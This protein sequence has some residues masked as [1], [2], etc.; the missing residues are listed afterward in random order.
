MATNLFARVQTESLRATSTTPREAIDAVFPDQNC[1]FANVIGNLANMDQNTLENL[2]DAILRQPITIEHNNFWTENL[3][4]DPETLSQEFSNLP[5]TTTLFLGIDYSQQLRPVCFR[6]EC[7]FC[8]HEIQPL[9]FQSPNELR[10]HLSTVHQYNLSD[11]QLLSYLTDAGLHNH[12]GGME[13]LEETLE[14]PNNEKIFNWYCRAPNCYACGHTAE[15]YHLHQQTFHNDKFINLHPFWANVFRHFTILD[16][17]PTMKEIFTTRKLARFTISINEN[18]IFTKIIANESKIVKSNDRLNEDTNNARI[19]SFNVTLKIYTPVFIA[20]QDST[21]ANR[22]ASYANM[23]QLDDNMF[24]H[25]EM[26][27]F[28]F[29]M[30]EFDAEWEYEG[31]THQERREATIEAID[32]DDFDIVNIDTAEDLEEF[33]NIIR[34]AL[35]TIDTVDQLN[36]YINEWEKVRFT[37]NSSEILNDTVDPPIIVK[38]IFTNASLPRA[39]Y[40]S[41]Y[42]GDHTAF[43]NIQ[44][45]KNYVNQREDWTYGKSTLELS[46]VYHWNITDRGR[47]RIKKSNDEI[48]SSTTP[49][50]CSF[51]DCD[52]VSTGPKRTSHEK[53]GKHAVTIT[54]RN[55]SEYQILNRF[56]FFW[57][58]QIAYLWKNGRLPCISALDKTNTRLYTCTEEGCDETFST[59]MA[60]KQHVKQRHNHQTPVYWDP[61]ERAISTLKFI[62]VD[63]EIELGRA[64]EERRR[65]N[66]ARPLI[67]NPN[68]PA[69]QNNQEQV[70]NQQNNNNNNNNNQNQIQNQNPQNG[71]QNGNQPD[72][73]NAQQQQQQQHNDNDNE[74]QNDDNAPLTAEQNSHRIAQARQW[75]RD[76]SKVENEPLNIPS[77]TRDRRIRLSKKDLKSLYTNTLIP[78]MKKFTP[79][80]DSEDERTKLDGVIYR[81]SELLRQFCVDALNIPKK[82]LI[83]NRNDAS[84]PQISNEEAADAAKLSLLSDTSKT[85]KILTEL[86]AIKDEAQQNGAETP[87][88]TNRINKLKR[89]LETI[90]H[91]R[92]A[93]WNRQVFGGNTIDAFVNTI[94]NNTEQFNRRLQWLKSKLDEDA[95]EFKKKC[96]AIRELFSDNPR[97][98]LNRYVYPKTTPEC[99]LSPE[100]FA[101]HY[102][103]Q[104]S[105]PMDDYVS[106]LGDD[107]WNIDRTVTSDSDVRLKSFMS[108]KAEIRKTI[109]SK[110]YLSAHGRDALSNALF[111]LAAEE[112]SELMKLIFESILTTKH[113]PSSWKISKTIMLYKKGDPQSPAN[114]RPIGLTST[115]YR[116]WSSHMSRFM[117][118]ENSRHQLFA[119]PQRGFI[120]ESGGPCDH[121]AALNEL[122]YMAKRQNTECVLVAIDF[123]NA[124]GTVPHQLIL[125][126]LKRKG[127]GETFTSVIGDLYTN[128]KTTIDVNGVRSGSINWNRGVLQGC[129]LSP[130]L[131]NAC[132]DPL[133]THLERFN[134]EDGIT[135]RVGEDDFTICCQAYAD[136]VVLVAKDIQGARREIESLE[137]FASRAGMTVAPH[138][139]VAITRTTQ[140]PEQLCINGTAIPMKKHTE[141]IGYLGA[142]ISGRKASRMKFA[143]AE[144]EDIKSKI[145]LV[146]KSQLTLI[147]KIEAVR[148][149]IL[150]RLDYILMNGQVA[151]ADLEGI[152]SLVRGNILK[153]VGARNIPRE[154]FH[155][156]T[157]HGGLSVEETAIRAETIKVSQFIR[158]CLSKQKHIRGLMNK[159][160]QDESTIRGIR[161]NP[162]SPFL[163]WE[164]VDGVISETRNRNTTNCLVSRAFEGASRLEIALHRTGDNAFTIETTG[165]SYVVTN[166]ASANK[167]IKNLINKRRLDSLTS[168]PQRGHSF[169]LPVSKQSHHYRNTRVNNNLILFT[170]KART[171]TLVT[172]ANAAAWHLTNDNTCPVCHRP[173]CTL[174]H[175]LNGCKPQRFPLYTWRHNIVCNTIKEAIVTKFNP[176]HLT[177]NSSIKPSDVNPEAD[178]SLLPPNLA[179]L[180]PD[181]VFVDPAT[182][183]LHI[184]EVTVPYAQQTMVD[185][186]IRETLEERAIGKRVKYE[187]LAQSIETITGTKTH[188][189][190]IVV[191]SLGHVPENTMLTLINLFGSKA[192]KIA[193]TISLMAL[194]CSAVI[195]T[196][197]PPESFGF[198]PKIPVPSINQSNEQPQQ[199]HQQEHQEQVQEQQTHQAQPQDHPA[200]VQEQD[201]AQQ[202]DHPA[203]VQ[204][205]DPAQ[206]EE[207]SQNEEESHNEE[208]SANNRDQREEEEEPDSSQQAST[209]QPP[210]NHEEEDS[211]DDQSDSVEEDNH[212]INQIL[213]HHEEDTNDYLEE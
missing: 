34:N 20:Q 24:T 46:T 103:P 61:G 75:I 40:G 71:Q 63:E 112:S 174:N 29:D 62:H 189:E 106:P 81:I 206:Q 50:I 186:E 110:N 164:I 84:R 191:S 173:K 58:P 32:Q 159:M 208:E 56:G 127:F 146:F 151:K 119:S 152:D 172:P 8:R 89:K 74:Q 180:K 52:Y 66:E 21:L 1:D 136:D 205:Q 83:R 76:Y 78:L 178:D 94:N 7:P 10:N 194:R 79:L 184:L 125:D 96:E 149:F 179:I 139:C 182:E 177:L 160:I 36:D 37:E 203:Q 202:Q 107:Q 141:L 45:L 181:L 157:D 114:W 82:K 147:Q 209:N 204:Q 69:Q 109:K 128:N 144:I 42:P 4:N 17:V 28:D 57:G 2:L 55:L 187:E 113:I 101:A 196:E 122:L 165:K 199:E 130:L 170:L 72:Q 176:T 33:E 85:I 15:E 43:D 53:N 163:D 135:Y 48:I 100:Q 77:M 54:G 67:E 68:P 44:K 51:L 105:I 70:Q 124:F 30:N 121:I 27:D 145:K 200:Q 193:S 31:V 154:V 80:D 16:H 155:L 185:N 212:E 190:I 99:T 213:N 138:K 5:A 153:D 3:L 143:A 87:I 137:Q 171:N 12:I 169:S 35:D 166:A 140:E 192:K 162:E 13:I 11:Q 108:D 90:L 158:L 201:Q 38:H 97:K 117:Q 183:D 167:S 131:F 98:C 93:E 142:P 195:F 198:S 41:P 18:N 156:D 23:E 197:E 134:K 126:S 210:R 148:T 47:W 104:W 59:S 150:P 88:Q 102:G 168:N 115:M 60:L 123:T 175:I 39:P 95:P 64:A 22:L 49:C 9:R 116:M 132:L 133:L 91:Q 26:E 129:P 25:P 19:N 73:Q 92:D 188:L 14:T 65:A 118:R 86:K 111:I 120:S 211:T 161:K 207:E 6:Y